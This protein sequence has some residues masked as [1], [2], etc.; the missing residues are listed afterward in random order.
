[1]VFSLLHFAPLFLVSDCIEYSQWKFH[2]RQEG[3]IFSGGSVGTK[4]GSGVTSAALTG[5][6]SYAG[7][8]SSASGLITQPQSA[9]DMIVSLYMYGP[10]LV[11]IVLIIVLLAYNLDKI[12]PQ[13][14]KDLAKREAEGKL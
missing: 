1:M 12:Y 3:L 4:I 6:L 11:W 8:V 14:M 13:I 9:I 7:Y 5:L 10:I 2:V